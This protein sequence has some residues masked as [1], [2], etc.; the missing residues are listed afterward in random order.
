MSTDEKQQ[1]DRNLEQY[2]VWVKTDPLKTDEDSDFELMNIDDSEDGGLPITEEEEKFIGELESSPY[3]NVSTGKAET[4]TTKNSDVDS[5]TSDIF[6][7]IEAKLDVLKDEIRS[8]KDQIS[9]LKSPLVNQTEGSEEPGGFFDNEDDET[10]ALTDD[11]LVNILD[12]ADMT[13]KAVDETEK[14]QLAGSDKLGTVIPITDDVTESDNLDEVETSVIEKEEM[15]RL[16]DETI[17]PLNEIEDLSEEDE[18]SGEFEKTDAKADIAEDATTE[19]SIETQSEELENK[20]LQVPSETAEAIENDVFDEG[21]EVEIGL[22]ERVVTEEGETHGVDVDMEE[23]S[24]DDFDLETQINETSDAIDDLAGTKRETSM[25]IVELSDVEIADMMSEESDVE[26]AHRIESKKVESEEEE[27]DE[28]EIAPELASE[29]EKL[30][31][32]ETDDEIIDESEEE[33]LDEIEIAPELASEAEKLDVIETDDEIIDES[34]EEEPDEIEIAPEL[35]SEA[36]KLDVIETDDEIIDESE[37]EEP[38]EIEIAPEL[39]SEAEKL[40]VIEIDDEI[41]DE[42]EEEEPDEIEIAPELASEAEK[43]D[44]IET[45][46]E[47]IDES[48]EEEPDEIEIAPELASEAEKLDVIE[49]DDEIIDESEEEEPDEIEIAP[50]LAS[51]AEKLDVIEIDDEMADLVDARSSSSSENTSSELPGTEETELDSL[52]VLTSSTETEESETLP[53]IEDF[54]EEDEFPSISDELKDEIKGILKYM[55]ELLVSLPEE[56]V[57]EFRRSEHFETYK[58]IFEELGISD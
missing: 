14:T 7:S 54:S 22:D 34:E 3:T 49:I 6:H 40:D 39:A 27:P 45:D 9:E 20:N 31:V 41:I 43:L 16:D 30:D 44:V 51:E 4:H 2:G 8:L 13:D 28:I 33:E 37:E 50:E 15:E 23:V 38:D 53:T 46:D 25:K 12:S 1:V 35:A 55:D 32:I 18:T 58:K 57:R 52:E 42:S 19:T 56:K 24:L 29:V 21:V 48:E 47:I 36:E 17:L 10:I 5:R 11:E 26:S